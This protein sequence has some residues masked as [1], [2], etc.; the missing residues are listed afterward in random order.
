MGQVDCP[1]HGPT[2]L[3]VVSPDIRDRLRAGQR[4]GELRAVRHVW[5]DRE[6]PDDHTD[7]WTM[8]Y[9]SPSHLRA[10]GVSDPPPPVLDDGSPPPPWVQAVNRTP[11]CQACLTEAYDGDPGLLPLTFR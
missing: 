6:D 3:I 1:R 7:V 4:I 11:V 9:V 8:G 2:A 10:H 5:I